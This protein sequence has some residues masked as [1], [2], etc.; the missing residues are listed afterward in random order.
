VK[1]AIQKCKDDKVKIQ[2]VIASN[3]QSEETKLDY[4]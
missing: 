3:K 2:K 1:L 4:L